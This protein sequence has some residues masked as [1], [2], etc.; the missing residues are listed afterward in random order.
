MSYSSSRNSSS[1]RPLRF[2]MSASVP[3]ASAECTGT[4]VLNTPSVER[5]SKET[6]LPYWRNSTKPARLRARTTRSPETLGNLATSVRDFD[7]R[8][9]F[10]W[11]DRSLFRRAPG[12]Q[13]QLNSFAQ[14]IARAFHV[15][16][17]RSHAQLWASS[18]VKLFFLSDQN[19]EPVVHMAMLA[20]VAQPGKQSS[21]QFRKL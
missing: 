7:G 1:V 8:P 12:F 11:L 10:L 16:A 14:I 6:R 4:T 20:A 3:L 18:D 17:L 21:N 13:I 9:E 19:R 2:R 5:F 15:A